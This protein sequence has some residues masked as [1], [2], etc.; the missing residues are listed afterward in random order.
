MSGYV[1]RFL[2]DIGDP[3][4]GPC[5]DQSGA[6]VERG[7]LLAEV[8]IPELD[9]ELRQKNAAVLQAKAEVQQARAAV[10]VAQTALRPAEEQ[11]QQ[12]LANL[13]AAE[14]DYSKWQS[15]Y[16]RVVKLA[17]SRPPRP[18]LSQSRSL[19]FQAVALMRRERYAPLVPSILLGT[20][21]GAMGAGISP[22]MAP[23]VGRL[24]L[25]A[26]AYWEVRNL[27]LG[28]R[29]AQQ[30]AGSIL[31][32]AQLQQIATMDLVAREITEAAALSRTAKKQIDVAREGVEAALQSYER[33]VARIQEGKGLPIEVMQAVQ[34]LAVA[35]REYLRT[36]IDYNSAQFSLLRAVGWPAQRA[37]RRG[38][39]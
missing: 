4:K 37:V 10:K 35:R 28:D 36:L 8:A 12:A 22:S 24:D 33:N 31:R 27:G 26:V 9:E 13:D 25:D 15:E 39:A 29:A 19:V 21:Y 5:Y 20:S 38:A 23:A 2:V 3:V 7:Q 11:Y 6:L 1:R 34:A 32:Q 30:N 16:Q 17:E 14:S 18:E